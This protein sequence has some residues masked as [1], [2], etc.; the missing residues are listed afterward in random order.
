MSSGGV[1]GRVGGVDSGECFVVAVFAMCMLCVCCVR[2]MGSCR[3]ACGSWSHGT[4][5]DEHDLA[6]TLDKL[7]HA[8]PQAE[9]RRSQLL[10]VGHQF[11][12]DG[13]GKL[14]DW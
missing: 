8:L 4:D 14:A 2:Y 5:G 12:G 13:G 7:D 10:L 1:V 11:I 3:G 9:E 6:P